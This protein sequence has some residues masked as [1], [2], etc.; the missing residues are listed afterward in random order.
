[1]NR[2]NVAS[3]SPLTTEAGGA[4]SPTWSWTVTGNSSRTA[5][6]S[7]SRIFFFNATPTT[8]I[9]TLSLHDALPIYRGPLAN[10]HRNGQPR[11]FRF[12]PRKPQFVGRQ[13]HSHNRAPG[14]RDGADSG[15]A[16][17]LFCRFRS[18]ERRVGKECRSRWSPYH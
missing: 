15:H 9:Y 10:G 5:S 12:R 4:P 16:I 6:S 7:S 11:A 14:C 3:S 2:R 17:L 1:M 8:E 18:E 13:R